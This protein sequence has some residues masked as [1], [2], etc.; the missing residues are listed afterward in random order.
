MKISNVQIAKMVANRGYDYQEA[1]DGIDAG[2]MPEQEE[3]EISAEELNDMIENI[4]SGFEQ[5]NEFRR[6]DMF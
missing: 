1:L 5:R 3:M 4:C 2:R 6:G